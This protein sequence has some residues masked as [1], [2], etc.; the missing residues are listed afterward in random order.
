[1]K[2][3]R[4]SYL[5]SSTERIETH[6]ST[7]PLPL[8]SGVQSTRRVQE[9]GQLELF[10]ICHS[11]NTDTIAHRAAQ[12]N[13]TRMS[14]ANKPTAAAVSQ[15]PWIKISVQTTVC[16]THQNKAVH[17]VF[18]EQSDAFN[19]AMEA[20]RNI[21]WPELTHTATTPHCLPEGYDANQ[22]S[23]DPNTTRLGVQSDTRFRLVD[24]FRTKGLK[25][26]VIDSKEDQESGNCVIEDSSVCDL[27]SEN[28]YT[29]I[30]G[31]TSSQ[32]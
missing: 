20:A 10:P 7:D 27:C 25:W 29:V 19:T 26:A 1:M 5:L 3:V 12:V 21:S 24:L 9:A 28:P 13:T 4:A 22:T 11:H 17:K 16:P 15:K 18:L 14:K 32:I 8:L 31:S 6:S 23:T 2:H 30:K